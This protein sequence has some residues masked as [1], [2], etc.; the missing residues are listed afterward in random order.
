MEMD[1]SNTVGARVGDL[2]AIELPERYL[3]KMMF[4]LYGLPLLAFVC[5]GLLARGLAGYMHFQAPD[6][7]AALAGACALGGTYA[8]LRWLFRRHPPE[9]PGHMVELVRKAASGTVGQPVD[10]Q[11]SVKHD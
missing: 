5:T 2:V 9:F 7:W 8:C 6:L 10:L 11:P 1:M 4:Y 3:L